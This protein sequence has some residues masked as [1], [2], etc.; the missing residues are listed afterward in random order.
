[1]SILTDVPAGQV[2]SMIRSIRSI[3]DLKNDEI[4]SI[5]GCSVNRV[6]NILACNTAPTHSEISVFELFLTVEL[7]EYEKRFLIEKHYP[8]LNLLRAQIS[9]DRAIDGLAVANSHWDSQIINKMCNYKNTRYLNIRVGESSKII[10]ASMI[11]KPSKGITPPSFITHRRSDLGSIRKVKGLIFGF[12]E[13]Q[14]I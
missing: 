3:R 7:E 1:M 13:S 2:A 5:L 9:F 6:A 8:H 10:I 12:G 14:S 11:I 4:A